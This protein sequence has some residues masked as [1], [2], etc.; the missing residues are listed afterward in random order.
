MEVSYK[1]RPLIWHSTC[2]VTSI[3]GLYVYVNGQQ[4]NYSGKYDP[5]PLNGSLVLGQEQDIVDGGYSLEQAFHGKI[6]R[7]NIWNGTLTFEEIKNVSLCQDLSN[8]KPLLPWELFMFNAF[9]ASGRIQVNYENVCSIDDNFAP[10]IYFLKKTPFKKASKFL[11]TIKLSMA[12]PKDEL[13]NEILSKYLCNLTSCWVNFAVGYFAHIGVKGNKRS[14]N[15]TFELEDTWGNQLNYSKLYAN[16]IDQYNCRKFVFYI[17]CKNYWGATCYSPKLCF[18]A[19]FN[20]Q[21]SQYYSLKLFVPK[22]FEIILKNYDKKFML[23]PQVK[24][25]IATFYG[26]GLYNIEKIDNSWCMTPKFSEGN[27]S[28][29]VL[30]IN[31]TKI[32]PIGCLK[33]TIMSSYISNDNNDNQLNVTFS[34]CNKTEFTCWD[35][36]CIS[37]DMRCDSET[38]CP[39]GEDEKECYQV[40]IPT[41]YMAQMSPE[42]NFVVSIHISVWRVGHINMNRRSIEVDFKFKTKWHDK[43]LQFRHLANDTMPLILKDNE[44]V[45]QQSL[46]TKMKYELP[47]Y[48]YT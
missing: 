8:K 4:F 24:T 12:F 9:N 10:F 18:A 41:G 37:L 34:S 15:A 19:R 36:T 40:N 11:Q 17:A 2:L 30:C 25:K 35:G 32:L 13:D 26:L 46:D 44:K 20:Q 27:I 39:E 6:S 7:L 21:L 14:K 48:I 47:F 43:R 33:W 29:A 42:N 31:T 1:I 5:I 3:N 23:M 16:N 22:S 45:N 28:E 38:H